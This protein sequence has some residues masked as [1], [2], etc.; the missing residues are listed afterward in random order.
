MRVLKQTF[1]VEWAHCDVAGIVFYPH[2][3]T[4]FDQASER[5]FSANGLSY[6]ALENEFDSSGMPLVETG[7][8]YFSPCKLGDT[9]NMESWVDEWAG[10]TFL[11]KHKLSHTDGR[12]ALEGFERRIWI[13]RDPEHPAGMRAYEVPEEVRRRFVD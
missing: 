6:E 4:W 1:N 5:L 9:L 13:R 3:Y 10:K 8:R 7:A 12:D 2:F 11:V